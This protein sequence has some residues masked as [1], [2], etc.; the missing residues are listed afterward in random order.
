MRPF[1]AAEAARR[2]GKTA[3]AAF[4][5]ALLEAGHVRGSDIQDRS[6]LE[7][8]ARDVGLDLARFRE[9]FPS[10][11]ALTRL[12][13]QHTFAVETLGIFG[14]PTLVFPEGQA[15]F[16]KM[17]SPPSPQESPAVFA[18]LSLLARRRNILEVKRPAP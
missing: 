7:R 2:Q 17:A 12:A 10:P 11:R 14:T 3:F 8:V 16:L 6:V 15:V 5:H 1:R 9:D 18:E 13:E 4:H